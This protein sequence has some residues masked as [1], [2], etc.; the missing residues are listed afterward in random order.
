[1]FINDPHSVVSSESVMFADDTTALSNVIT[2][3]EVSH[4]IEVNVNMIDIY[5]AKNHLVPHPKKTKSILFSKPSQ[6]SQPDERVNLTLA[7]KNFEYV[8]VYKCL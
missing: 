2:H 6:Y 4:D 1:M 8:S 5:T 7:V 3:T